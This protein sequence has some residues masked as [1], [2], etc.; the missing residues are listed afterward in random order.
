KPDVAMP[1]NDALK[2][3]HNEALKALGLRSAAP[4]V[5]NSPARDLLEAWVKSFNE[6]DAAARQAW[7]RANTTLPDAQVAEYASLDVQIR[8]SEGPFDIAR[9]DDVTATSAVALARHRKSGNGGRIEIV[10]DP[11]EPKKIA[12]IGL[13]PAELED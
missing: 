4:P 1:A 12:K 5:A 7:L 10:L 6:H 13:Q 8:D 3:A 2:F 11:K 9:F